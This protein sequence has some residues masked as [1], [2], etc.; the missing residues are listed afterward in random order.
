MSESMVMSDGSAFP[1]LEPNLFSFNSPVGACPSCNGLGFIM[2]IDPN[3]VY[4]PRLT[5]S[6]GSIYPW[7]RSW[8]M[9]G[10][11]YRTMLEQVAKKHKVDLKTPMGKLAKEKLYL[12]LYGTGDMTYKVTMESGHSFNGKYE[13][14]IPIFL[15]VSKKLKVTT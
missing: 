6:E 10:G 14:V 11:W 15:V 4:N 9:N 7:S 13:G 8:D 1:K 3:L 5:I 2:E 12:I